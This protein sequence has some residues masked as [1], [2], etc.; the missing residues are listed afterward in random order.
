MYG[1]A[2]LESCSVGKIEAAQW[3]VTAIFSFASYTGCPACP[4]MELGDAYRLPCHYFGSSFPSRLHS[5]A[6]SWLPNWHNT[7][8]NRIS[9]SYLTAWVTGTETVTMTQ[10]YGSILIALSQFFP[11]L[12]Q[13]ALERKKPIR[14]HGHTL[15]SASISAASSPGC[16]Y[17]QQHL[18]ARQRIVYLWD[19]GW[20]NIQKLM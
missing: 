2:W 7:L 3:C 10:N 8:N 17:S 16:G 9:S 14:W 18:T 19:E 1:E 11:S 20:L 6:V 5:V 12:K 13:T 15:E 4:V